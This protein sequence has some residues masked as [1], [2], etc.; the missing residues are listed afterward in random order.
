MK[1][2]LYAA[3]EGAVINCASSNRIRILNSHTGLPVSS[4]SAAAH[5]PQLSWGPTRPHTSYPE[6]E[7]SQCSS[8]YTSRQDRSTRTQSLSSSGASGTGRPD[9]NNYK[10][11]SNLS[12]PRFNSRTK[13]IWDEQVSEAKTWMELKEIMDQGPGGSAQ[14]LNPAQLAKLMKQLKLIGSQRQRKSTKYADS[15]WRE[16]L[17]K[18]AAAIH[19][20]LPKIA[21]GTASAMLWT[22][23][24]LE[25]H[26]GEVWAGDMAMHLAPHLDG[27]DSINFCQVAWA[28]AKIGHKPN[29]EWLAQYY[30]VAISRLEDGD[31]APKANERGRLLRCPKGSLRAGSSQPE[32]LPGYCVVKQANEKG[33]LLRCP[34]E[35]VAPLAS[36]RVDLDSA[37]LNSVLLQVLDVANGK[38]VLLQVLDVANGKVTERGATAV[39]QPTDISHITWAMARFRLGDSEFQ[40]P[41]GLVGALILRSAECV[42]Q[43]KSQDYVHKSKNCVSQ[44][45]AQCGDD[46][47]LP[48]LLSLRHILDTIHES[49]SLRYLAAALSKSADS[50]NVPIVEALLYDQGLQVKLAMADHPL[51]ALVLRILGHQH[52]AWDS[53]HLT[54]PV[55]CNRM[56]NLHWLLREATLPALNGPVSELAKWA[57]NDVKQKCLGFTTHLLFVF[58]AN[59]EGHMQSMKNHPSAARLFVERAAST[60]DLETEFSLVWLT[61]WELAAT[62]QLSHFNA[63]ELS[64]AMWT[65]AVVGHKPGLKFSKPFF[66]KCMVKLTYFNAQLSNAMWTLAIVG[67]KPGLKFPKPFFFKCMGK[68]TYFNAQDCSTLLWALGRLRMKPPPRWADAMFEESFTQIPYFNTEHFANFLWGWSRMD[69]CP[70][71]VWLDRFFYESHP[72]LPDFS[73]RE[74][75]SLAF[76]LATTLEIRP[77]QPWMNQFLV[78]TYTQMSEF[79]PKG[80]ASV[81]RCLVVLQFYPNSAWVSAMSKAVD[82][83]ARSMT[84]GEAA[85]LDDCYQQLGQSLPLGLENRLKVGKAARASASL[86]TGEKAE[87]QLGQAP[88]LRLDNRLKVG[89][90]ARASASLGTGEKA[91]G[92]LGQAPP[93]KLENRL[94]VGKAARASASLGTGEKNEGQLGQAPPLGLENRL[95]VGKAA[96]ASAS[97]GTGE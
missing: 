97:L 82:A 75:S 92:Q 27:V 4:C 2:S 50:Q 88:P 56:A 35:S 55:R 68:L 94:K 26:P 53:P 76:S 38:V 33:R 10:P 89:K 14:R 1:L 18:V 84:E 79:S 77:P 61:T 73:A 46:G 11:P 66:S 62:V 32:D 86:G 3:P 31:V 17:S 51:E 24:R 25:F 28:F 19:S 91:E 49:P 23:G 9:F 74:L 78:A 80:L 12:R 42:Q 57:N 67:H 63:Q 54:R 6:S 72:R 60:D 40:I 16:F 20:E 13:S 22:F 95:K 36:L 15:G 48:G 8:S 47:E 85:L 44:L 5:R 37:W 39:L 87:G 41:E 52:Q 43:F 45:R 29:A 81:L 93:L 7:A 58:M 70:P 59:I 83:R 71:Q 65:L 30:D 69:Y 96:R 90:A 21:P 64:N 34:W